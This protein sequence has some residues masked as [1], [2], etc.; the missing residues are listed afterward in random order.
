PRYISPLQ[1]SVVIKSLPPETSSV[2]V[3]VDEQS[4]E[5]VMKLAATAGIRILQLHGQEDPQF[6]AELKKHNFTII[7]ALRAGPDLSIKLAQ[8]YDV[9]WILLD[10]YDAKLPGGTGKT[11]DWQL[12]RQIRNSVRGSVKER[13][14]FLA[15]GLNTDNINRALS[16]V[17]PDGV[18][19]TSGVE[20]SPGVKDDRL[21]HQFIDAVRQFC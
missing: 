9:D 2:G 20:K 13:A 14:I 15:G 8:S 6:C 4:P 7:K 16:T 18:D 1:A 12:A 5:A 3:F 17:R 10:A 19:V 21:I 11:F